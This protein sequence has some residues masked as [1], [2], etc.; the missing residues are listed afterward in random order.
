MRV[1]GMRQSHGLF[2]TTRTDIED[3]VERSG[4]LGDRL[5]EEAR[6]RMSGGRGEEG[7]HTEGLQV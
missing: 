7:D 4:R 3:A 1:G 6:D 2:G 5:F